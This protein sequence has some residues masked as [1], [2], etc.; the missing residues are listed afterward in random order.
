MGCT[1]LDFIKIYRETT[2]PLCYPP[3]VYPIKVLMNLW[4]HRMANG[5]Q[6][7]HN[8]H[9][10]LEGGSCQRTCGCATWEWYG[11]WCGWRCSAGDVF[12]DESIT[13]KQVENYSNYCHDADGDGDGGGDGE[14]EGEYGENGVCC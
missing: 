1:Q 10:R 4:Q 2:L 13:A 12:V 14:G 5:L 3:F 8:D 9:R 7:R 6:P 11:W